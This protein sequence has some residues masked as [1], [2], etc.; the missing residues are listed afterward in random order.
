MADELRARDIQR[1]LAAHD[2]VLSGSGGC[3]VAGGVPGVQGRAQA[4]IGR[5][6]FGDT[7]RLRRVG[8][9]GPRSVGVKQ[10]AEP[11]FAVASRGERQLGFAT[12]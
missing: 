3:A 11:G 4:W 10:Q 7:L 12:A 8:E 5:A 6:A 9:A 2:G 1:I